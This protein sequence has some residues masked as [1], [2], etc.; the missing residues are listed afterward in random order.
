[1]SC[2][3]YHEINLDW[4]INQIKNALGEWEIVKGKWNSLE[5]YVQ[6]YFNNLD[7]SDE[8]SNKIDEMYKSG[9]FQEL[10]KN[11]NLLSDIYRNKHA[12][13]IGDS[14]LAIN[15]ETE[16]WGAL[17][18]I[19]LN[20]S[21]FYVN[22]SGSASFIGLPSYKT[23]L[24]LLQEINVEDKN[25]ITDIVVLGGLND[26]TALR[27]IGSTPQT[28]RDSIK[29]FFT[30]ANQN[31][32]NAKIRIG[33]CGW[34]NGYTNERQYQLDVY[35]VYTQAGFQGHK[36]ATV[37]NV[38]YIMLNKSS[39][40]EDNVHPTAAASGVIALCVAYALTESTMTFSASKV[41]KLN[42]DEGYTCETNFLQRINNNIVTISCEPNIDATIPH[43]DNVLS[44]IKIGTFT[45]GFIQGSETD[46]IKKLC[47]I[48]IAGSNLTFN[49]YVGYVIIRD[50]VLYIKPVYKLSGDGNLDGKLRIIVDMGSIS[51]YSLRVG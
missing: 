45:S 6:N 11:V 18:K 26:A 1:M 3:D 4:L 43:I 28:L 46:N 29:E 41:A 20:E 40:K 13:L 38:E 8:V 33:Y 22:G 17:L 44:E 30:Y 34:T 5:E 50:S 36:C 48:Q 15:Q 7:L 39:F 31:Y 35:S 24:Q 25:S 42:T 12:I 51:D 27:T 23:F 49:Q 37:P 14:Y 21:T 9:E 2:C 32:P 47:F 16:S 19:I 10:F